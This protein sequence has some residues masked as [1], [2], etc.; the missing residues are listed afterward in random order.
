MISTL[1]SGKAID[2]TTTVIIN[3]DD[4][5]KGLVENSPAL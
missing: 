1:K 2:D 3:E 5:K 4:L